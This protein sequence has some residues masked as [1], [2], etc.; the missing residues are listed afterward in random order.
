MNNYYQAI[1]IFYDFLNKPVYI[2]YLKEKDLYDRFNSFYNIFTKWNIINYFVHDFENI[3]TLIS[4]HNELYINNEL[5]EAYELFN[6]INGYSLDLEQRRAIVIDE[7]NQLLIAGAGSG[8]SLTLIGNICY[9][10]KRMG[11]NEKEILCIS[12]T[13]DAVNSLKQK[14]IDKYNYDI[15]VFTFHKLGLDIIRKYNGNVDIADSNMLSD[16]IDRYL[17][18]D[19]LKSKYGMK[20]ILMFLKKPFL[21]QNILYYYQKYVKKEAKLF[22]N[23]KILI[24]KFIFLFKANN[25]PVTK[26]NEFINETTKFPNNIFNYCNKYFIYI[27][28]QIYYLYQKELESENM[29]DFD[30]MLILANQY[31]KNGLVSLK[32]RYILIDEYQDTSKLRLSLIQSIQEKTGAKI[33]AVGDDFQSIYRFTGCDLNIFLNFNEYFKGCNISKIQTTYRNSQELINIAGAFVMKNKSQLF[34]KLTSSKHCDKPIEII[35]YV[36]I[37]E[38]F[39]KAINYIYKKTSKPILILGRNNYDIFK[40]DKDIKVDQSGNIENDIP[41][42]YLTVHKAKGLEEENVIVIN[43]ENK[44][45]GF[46]NQMADYKLLSLVLS[47]KNMF[48]YEEER[49][50]FYVALTRT[51]NKVYLLVPYFNKSIFINEIIRDFKKDIKF[52]RL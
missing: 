2:D 45:D 30:D 33:I 15:P 24:N 34:K 7:V 5:Y 3:K 12:F 20:Y 26:F 29:I 16:I 21:P 13:N 8:K 17:Y 22:N 38:S 25:F 40:V 9:L 6:N 14:L 36:N 47:K 41:L 39:Y 44:V 11:I 27:V 10:I 35:N 46:P 4:K 52:I 23:L 42:R 37:K 1:S 43:L 19:V 50:L 32:Y 51:K 49:R 28:F 18:T 48:P 31:I